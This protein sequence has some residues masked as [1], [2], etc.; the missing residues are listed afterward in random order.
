MIG[1]LHKKQQQQQQQQQQIHT[2]R[3]LFML[4]I[5]E[6]AVITANMPK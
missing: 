4:K 1:E 3:V 5:I 2:M 6:R